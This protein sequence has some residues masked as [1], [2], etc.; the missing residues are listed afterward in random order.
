MVN[1]ALLGPIVNF[2]LLGPL[3][4]FAL[5]GLM[6][7]FA[8]LGPTVNRDISCTHDPEGDPNC[9]ENSF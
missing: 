6:V 2:A 8:L 9:V 7:N 3:V 1:F 5:L 4:N